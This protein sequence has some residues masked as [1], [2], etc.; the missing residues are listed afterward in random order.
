MIF[1][2]DNSNWWAAFARWVFQL[3]GHTRTRLLD[4]GRAKWF[5]EGRPS[6]TTVPIRTQSN[7][8]VRDHRRHEAIRA[9]YEETRAHSHAGL[10]LVDVRSPRE[11]AGEI[12]HP[13]EFP[14]E[15]AQLA[16]HIPGACSVPWTLAV[17]EKGTFKSTAKLREIYEEKHGLRHDDDIIV[18]CRIGERASHTWFVLT[19]LLGFRRVRNYAGSWSE[20]GNHSGSPV[21]T[22]DVSAPRVNPDTIAISFRR[23]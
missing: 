10:P 16:G 20:W 19:Q 3:N 11:F 23:S 22:V 2:G 13:P 9:G 18:Y 14:G 15:A 12:T 17:T 1:Y 8:P 21:A 5:A 7:Y 6:I 4:G